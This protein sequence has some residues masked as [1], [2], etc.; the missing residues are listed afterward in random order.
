MGVRQVL[1]SLG[2]RPVNQHKTAIED[3]PNRIRM[4]LAA[5]M[6]GV[7]AVIVIM[8]IWMTD[9]MDE[10]A[11][12]YAA[13]LIELSLREQTS[14]IYTVTQDEARWGA[15]DSWIL[16]PNGQAIYGDVG[17]SATGTG[18][19]DL[20]YIFSRSDKVLYVYEKTP[21]SGETR[22][23]VYAALAPFITAVHDAPLQTGFVANGFTDIDGELAFVAATR[24]SPQNRSA[25]SAADLPVVTNILILNDANL[26]GINQGQLAR[27]IEVA[28]AST[29]HGSELALPLFGR[30]AFAY[31]CWTPPAVGQ[32][33]L[34]RST[35]F[36][37]G[38][39]VVITLGHFYV[40]HI[41]SRLARA[42]LQESEDARTDGLTGLLNRTGF[43][44][45]MESPE[46]AKAMRAGHLGVVIFDMDKFKPINDSYGHHVGDVALQ[47]VAQRLQSS[48][49][50]RDLVARLGGD[51]F[52]AVVIDPDPERVVKKVMLRMEQANL[53]PIKVDDHVLTL[54]ASMG[55]ALASDA[56]DLRQ[57]MMAA[58]ASMYAAKTAK[59][60]REDV[61]GAVA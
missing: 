11:Q 50:A 39:L 10:L 51:E 46:I 37:A 5:M 47:T 7:M 61:E 17:S 59:E 3:I 15:G 25:F 13:E 38:L 8:V 43:D 28:F 55:F 32:Q 60:F 45:A 54:E 48:A 18:T 56:G 41:V 12:E 14:T 57:L 26:E 4:S 9:I 21:L 16:A 52:A 23:N 53:S 24:M 36:I 29:D 35:R 42:F 1:N 20:S 40:S 2:P 58:D 44:E 31:L 22:T 19:V 33:V 30:D 6:F 49:R 27:N 34:S